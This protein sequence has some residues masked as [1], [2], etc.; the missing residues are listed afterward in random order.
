MPLEQW[1]FDGR[2]TKLI[3][4]EVC[5]LHITLCLWVDALYHISLHALCAVCVCISVALKEQLLL[6]STYDIVRVYRLMIS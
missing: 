5:R 4:K 3:S 2:R 1:I 6:L